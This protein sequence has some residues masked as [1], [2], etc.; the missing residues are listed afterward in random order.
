MPVQEPQTS[1]NDMNIGNENCMEI[2]TPFKE[3]WEVERKHV[4]SA[5]LF[6]ISSAKDESDG[7]TL[8]VSLFR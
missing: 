4:G 1:P 2:L 3:R 7:T 8:L 5:L 6:L